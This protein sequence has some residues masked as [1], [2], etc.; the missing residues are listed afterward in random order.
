MITDCPST[1]PV[2]HYEYSISP[3][4]LK[5]EFHSKMNVQ[6]VSIQE[7]FFFR[8]Q[9]KAKIFQ[10][11]DRLEGWCSK[12]KASVLVDFVFL[13]QPKKIVEIGVFGGKSLVPMAYAIKANNTEGKVYGIDPWSSEESGKDME[14]VNY[15]WWT[16]VDHNRILSGLESRIREFELE[17]EI[18]L[19]RATS[20]EAEEIFD[21]DMLHIDGNHSDMASY[22][23]VTKWVPLVRSG[24]L[25][26][27]DDI[28]WSTTSRAVQW[29][30]ENCTKLSEYRGDN[31]W[32]I[33]VKP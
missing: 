20:E 31:I 30:D 7:N 27:F 28:N 16:R 5:A 3:S 11:M 24:G 22:I 18:E 13:L 15:E 2:S 17:S 19:I 6:P 23:D 1:E 29:L 10:S 32:G 12:Y 8:D 21:I 26:I 33:W 4:A 9:L 25:I 14:G